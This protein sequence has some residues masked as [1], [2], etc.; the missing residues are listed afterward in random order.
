MICEMSDEEIIEI[1]KAH[2]DGKA[3]EFSV[4]GTDNWN[5]IDKPCWDF[6]E[7]RYRVKEKHSECEIKPFK[8]VVEF[9]RYWQRARERVLGKDGCL[10]VGGIWLSLKDNDRIQHMVTAID[11]VG[12]LVFVD[13]YWCN[14]RDLTIEF[15][16]SDG[17]PCGVIND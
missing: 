4:I 11:W 2:K 5:L 8:N 14:M 13:N 7:F 15:C 10:D 1:V 16:F 17:S 6:T 3:I 12:N 9:I